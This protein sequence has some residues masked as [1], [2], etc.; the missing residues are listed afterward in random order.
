MHMTGKEKTLAIKPVHEVLA[1]VVAVSGAESGVVGTGIFTTSN[2]KKRC[3]ELTAVPVPRQR[4]Q[5]IP[6]PYGSRLDARP[7]ILQKERRAAFFVRGSGDNRGAI[8][9]TARTGC[10]LLFR[11][12]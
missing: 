7:E 3:S 11:P 8:T 1:A 2:C 9:A 5:I 6:Q 4:A 12:E 10:L